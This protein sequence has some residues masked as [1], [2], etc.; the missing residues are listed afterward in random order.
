MIS[1]YLFPKDGGV[2]VSIALDLISYSTCLAQGHSTMTR[3][4]EISKDNSNS[5]ALR[6][7]PSESYIDSVTTFFKKEMH[8]Y[9]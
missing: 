7:M 6:F 9:L 1:I 3:N 5:C 4:S 8:S 2:K